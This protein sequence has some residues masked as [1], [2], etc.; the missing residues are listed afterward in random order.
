[1]KLEMCL[2]LSCIFISSLNQGTYNVAGMMVAV[3]IVHGGVPVNFFAQSFF[4]IIAFG[5]EACHPT[6]CDVSDYEI[7]G[8]IEAVSSSLFL[9]EHVYDHVC[10]C[11]P[12]RMDVACIDGYV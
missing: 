8:L 2:M 4:E 6:L 11:M 3:I 9:A 12:W 1:M 7:R 5:F 10:A